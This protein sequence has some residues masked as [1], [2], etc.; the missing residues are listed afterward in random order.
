MLKIAICD[1]EKGTLLRMREYLRDFE[2]L[3]QVDTYQSGEAL[4]MAGERY[5]FYFLDIDMKGMSGID[6]ARH[7]RRTDRRAKI[8]YVTAYEDF[9]EYAFSVHAFAYLVKPVSRERFQKIL[10][11][12]LAYREEEKPERTIRLETEEGW[13]E[14]SVSDIYYF[15]YQNRKIRM[16]TKAGEAWLRGSIMALGQ[17][18]EGYGFLMPHKSFLV[19]LAHVR[20]LKGYDIILTEGSWIPLSQKKAADFRRRLTAYLV[21]QI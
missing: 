20:N 19:N 9:R 8:I 13:K 14:V 11:E 1:D 7:I 12:A 6:T 3:F 21:E 17:R 10:R 16:V 4:L 5:D 15:E 2:K 18:M